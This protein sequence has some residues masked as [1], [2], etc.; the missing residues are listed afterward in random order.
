MIEH[1]YFYMGLAFLLV[2]EMDAVRLQEWRM[3]PFLSR[4]EDETGYLIFTLLH[5]PLYGL[6]FWGLWFSE[7]ITVNLII[8]LDLFFIIH[9]G[10]HLLLLK[11]RNNQF[12]N[13]FSWG[14]ILLTGIFG[15]LDLFTGF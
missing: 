10:L 7:S 8:G 15:I 4:L 12:R 1:Y 6:L 13:Y 14:L 9:L 3:M 11:H 2:H 5:I